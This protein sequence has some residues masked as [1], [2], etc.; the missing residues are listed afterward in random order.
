[1]EINDDVFTLN[2]SIFKN[3]T[4]KIKKE[5]ANAGV[6]RDSSF[7]WGS[8]CTHFVVTYQSLTQEVMGSNNPFNFKY[9]VLRDLDLNYWRTFQMVSEFCTVS[10]LPD[11]KN[12]E[13][14]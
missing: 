2:V 4:S 10:Y 12:N 3:A 5:N 11:L 6:V 13:L 1:M 7:T 8:T 14:N 9:F